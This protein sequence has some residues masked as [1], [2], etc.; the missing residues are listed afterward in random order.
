[1]MKNRKPL[2]LTLP[3]RLY[4]IYQII[5]C[6]VYIKICHENN[7]ALRDIWKC[8]PD[9]KLKGYADEQMILQ[10]SYGWYYIMVRLSELIETVFFVLRKKNDQVSILHVYHHIST[11][12][13][14]STFLL[15]SGGMME[16]NSALMNNAVHLVMYTYY[17][18]SSFKI[19]Q[20]FTSKLKPFLT[21]IQIAQLFAIFGQTII[22]VLPNCHATW[23]F[24][25]QFLNVFILILMFLAFYFKS[26]VKKSE[27]SK[28]E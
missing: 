28:F 13:V 16:F 17:L 20:K 23:V 22:A 19:L 5:V 8:I 2:N 12:Y 1:M 21:A 24:K 27:K 14:L 9:P 26:Y 4:N 15:E 3:V 11:V 18:L 6:A 25:L 7:L 10:M